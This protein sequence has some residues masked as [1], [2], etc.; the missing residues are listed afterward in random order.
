[1]NR[2]D[3]LRALREA[4]QTWDVL[5]IG[6]GATGLGSALDAASRGFRTALV[7][8]HDFAK[9]TSGRS[10]KLI[11][12]GVRYLRQGNLALVRDSLRERGLL[13]QNAPHLVR[14]L[15]FVVPC[16]TWSD[17]PFYGIG[18]KLY[19]ALAGSLGLGATELLSRSEALARVPGVCADGLRGGV[20]YWDAQFD[21]AR[22]ALALAR[23]VFDYGG[24]AA[25]YV[26]VETLLKRDGR[27]CGARVRDME[28][29]AEFE[30]KARVVVN[31]TGVFTDPVRRLDDGN[32]PPMIAAS[33][34]AH[35][36]LPREFLPGDSAL[37]VPKTDDGRVL[38]AIPWHGRVVVG[39]TDTPVSETPLDPRPREDEV[40]FLLSHAAEHLA[41]APSTADV[42]S[43][44]AGLRPLV[45]GGSGASTSRLSRD[46]TLVVSDSGLVT[47]A[48][49]KWTTYRKMAEDTVDRVA[50]V[51]GL[52]RRPCVTAKLE[53]PDDGS[54]LPAFGYADGVATTRDALEPL[55]REGVRS[56][57]AR[58]V[59]DFLARRTRWLMLDARGSVVVAP[60]VAELMAK[61][62]GCDANWAG[63]QTR[64]FAE[65]ARGYCGA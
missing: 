47:I 60:L 58:T 43:A 1:M 63:R 46:H 18:L 53:L 45:K 11:H 15:A 64:A 14:K 36:V 33:Q 56:E 24:V 9:A 51:G 12:G 21:D 2:D 29:G 48:G 41:R 8:Q 55:V 39:T 7:E 62:L 65:L 32:S 19:D 49:G 57:M 5:V 50:V 54:G 27:V 23:A 16:R 10:T 26:R 25:N 61:E 31:A 3:A 42:L 13:L 34:G 59:E 37:M 30:V 6:G 22:L 20:L 35:L 40:Q 38:F 4:G 17:R 52:G 28:S 44:W